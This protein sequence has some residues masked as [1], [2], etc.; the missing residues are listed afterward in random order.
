MSAG[1]LVAWRKKPGDAVTRG[2]IIAEVETDK[3]A[4]RHRGVHHRRAREDPGPAG[5]QG[6]GRARVLAI[7]DD[8]GV[9]RGACT[10]RFSAAAGRGAGAGRR[11]SRAGRPRAA[12]DLAAGAEARGPSSASIPRRSAARDPAER[13]GSEDIEQAAACQGGAA[14]PT[15]ARGRRPAGPA[16]TGDRRRHGALQARDPPLLPEHHDRHAPR[17]DLADRG[18]PRGGRSP[19]ACSTAS[20]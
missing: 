1:T 4:D 6:P 13:S 14:P 12:P 2:D 16:P 19:S 10:R 11:A 7:I 8:E 17:D 20:C 18:E 5:R 3:G 15:A 9:A